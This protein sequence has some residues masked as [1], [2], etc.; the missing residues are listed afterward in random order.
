MRKILLLVSFSLLLSGCAIQMR[1]GNVFY[2]LGIPQSVFVSNNKLQTGDLYRN[3]VLIATLRTGDTAR[4]SLT[5]DMLANVVITFKAFELGPSGEK[6][7][8]GLITR[9]FK[10]QSYSN[11]NQEWTVDYVQPPR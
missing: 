7:Y 4:V 3:N 8:Y 11:D 10:P 2:P 6:N 1:N 5:Y 9:T